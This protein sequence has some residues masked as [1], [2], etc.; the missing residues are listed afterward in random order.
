MSLDQLTPAERQQS[1]SDSFANKSLH[2]MQARMA[3]AEREKENEV[4]DTLD[5]GL[6]TQK[7]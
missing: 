5:Q 4:L 3:R 7:D 1:Y 2:D 6:D